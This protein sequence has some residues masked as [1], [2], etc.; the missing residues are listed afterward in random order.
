MK[1]LS[2]VLALAFGLSLQAQ[3]IK[4]RSGYVKFFSDAPVEDIT[5]ENNQVS[6]ILDLES[7]SFAFLVPI[8]AF[9]FEKA[10]MQEHFNENYMESGKFPK[11]T[12]KGKIANFEGF[13]LSKDGQYKATFVGTMDMHGQSQE[14][15]ETVLITIKDGKVQLSGEFYLNCSDYG[16]EIPATKKD[17]I[18]DKLLI[19][20]K[21]DYA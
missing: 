4:T 20:V 18:S 12:F 8:K 11:A 3:K 6:S 9:Q 10:L 7:G 17:N 2:L 19:T 14:I 15:S 1:Y 21:I 5:A 13:D 16:I